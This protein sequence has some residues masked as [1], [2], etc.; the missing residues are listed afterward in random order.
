[1]T[2]KYLIIDNGIN[3]GRIKAL[4]DFGTI[5]KGTIGGYVDSYKN[6]SQEG[7]AW[8]YGNARVSGNAKVSAHVHLK[9]NLCNFDVQQNLKGLIYCS[10]NY[11]PLNNKYIFY[12]KVNSTD[13]KNTFSAI[14]DKRI[15]YIIGKTTKVEDID[16]DWSI[17]CGKGLHVSH[18]SYWNEG[19]SL[20][21]VEVDIKD[22][23]TCQEGKL[24][25]KKLK[26]LG[27]VDTL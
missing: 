10:L 1:M 7:Y 25:C 8:V 21:A 24:R 14:Y 17:S 11:L 2:D 3:K 16:D 27:V 13:K 18:P 20:I 5:T 26:V 6:L 4:K 19:D 22:I 12:K 15:N 9:Y 23:I